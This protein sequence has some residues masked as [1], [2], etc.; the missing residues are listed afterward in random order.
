MKALPEAQKRREDEL[1]AI[2]KSKQG[3]Y[4]PGHHG[5]GSWATT[6]SNEFIAASRELCAL[7]KVAGEYFPYHALSRSFRQAGIK[8]CRG[9]EMTFKRAEY[10][11]N[12][13]LRD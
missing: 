2:C 10:L 9:A 4:L 3:E 11:Y 13:H 6:Y 1:L 7:Y 12:T 8:S 5:R